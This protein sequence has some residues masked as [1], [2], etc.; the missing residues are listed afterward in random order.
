M[1]NA[2]GG[3]QLNSGTY[4]FR[5]P[6]LTC[7]NGDTKTKVIFSFPKQSGEIDWMHASARALCEK[8][9]PEPWVC[10]CTVFGQVQAGLHK[11]LPE[12]L[13][14]GE[15]NRSKIYAPWARR[16]TDCNNEVSSLA[17]Y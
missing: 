17:L 4:I 16:P 15:I 13:V 11:S 1:S 14:D 3:E 6:S 5:S 2:I 10:W 7:V 8:P 12:S 9:C